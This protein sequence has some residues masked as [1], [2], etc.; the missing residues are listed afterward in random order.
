MKIELDFD[1]DS[2][3][4]AKLDAAI[5]KA[6]TAVS[7]EVRNRAINYAPVDKG[8]LKNHIYREVKGND[9]VV[10]NTMPYAEYVEF[11]TKAHEIVAKNA[12]VLSDGKKV[13]GKR[14]WHPG[15]KGSRFMRR[16]IYNNR[17]GIISV[18]QNSLK[19]SL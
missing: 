13:F 17:A 3:L 10:Y 5:N 7:I 6:L 8:F 14:V 19:A 1:I 16:S 12:K 2:M 11:G 15:T 4:P 18:F 9:A